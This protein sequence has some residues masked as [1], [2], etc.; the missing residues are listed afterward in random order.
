MR[1]RPTRLGF[2][3]SLVL[4]LCTAA[5][6]DARGD[7]QI[8]KETDAKKYTIYTLVNAGEQT[9]RVKI[10]FDKQCTGVANNQEP[11]EQE[12][13]LA[14]K[15]SVELGRIW[16]QSTCKRDYRIVQADYPQG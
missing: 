8:K 16:P 4:L 11:A 14:P 9:V 3:L 10:R 15:G 12:Y 13:V 2:V 1:R 5:L 6:A 7:L